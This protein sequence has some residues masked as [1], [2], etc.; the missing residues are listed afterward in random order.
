MT[1]SRCVRVVVCGRP[2]VGRRASSAFFARIKQIMLRRTNE[3][4]SKYLPAK[5]DVCVFCTLTI[6]QQQLY[7][8]V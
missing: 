8:K 1:P 2:Q 7:L 3:V 4:I 6:E 5:L